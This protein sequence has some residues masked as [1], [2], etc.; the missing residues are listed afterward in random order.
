MVTDTVHRIVP[1]VASAV[2]PF[3]YLRQR[4]EGEPVERRYVP[5]GSG[6]MYAEISGV[7]QPLILVHGLGGSTRWWAR[8]VPAL[9][10]SC[11]V[12]VIDLLGFGRSR[13]QR[14][15][16]REAAELLVGMMDRLGLARTSVVGHSMGGLIAASVAAQC[17]ARVERLVLVDA[18][19]LPLERLSLRQ[20]W[21]MVRGLPHLPLTLLPV[22]GTDALRA[23][24]VTLIKALR[25]LLSM[26]IRLDLARIEAPTLILWGEHDATLPLAVGKRLHEHLPQAAFR[27]IA[28]A[29]HVPMWECPTAFNQ[30]VIQFLGGGNAPPPG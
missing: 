15:V 14:F 18:A 7:G 4:R 13:G 25:E 2:P 11:R 28:G 23:G 12:H 8:N 16:L 20:A 26:D 29:G 10:R 30:A 3:R 27:V 9:A 5:V 19:A 21:R 17:P 6:T 22:L 1:G 24:P